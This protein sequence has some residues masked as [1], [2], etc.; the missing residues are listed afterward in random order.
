MTTP[1]LN[2]ELTVTATRPNTETTATT[3]SNTLNQQTSYVQYP[4]FNILINGTA[5]AYPMSFDIVTNNYSEASRFTATF[6]LTQTQAADLMSEA[7][8]SCEVQVTLKDADT[9]LSLIYGLVD[10][11]ELDALHLHVVLTG[12]D[13]AGLLLDTP[14]Q[15][16]YENMTSSQVIQQFVQEHADQG[17]K[18]AITATS[19]LI[20]RFYGESYDFTKFG[21]LYHP[22]NEW[23]F[24]LFLAQGEGFDLRL[25]GPDANGKLLD[26]KTLYFGPPSPSEAKTYAIAVDY[27]PPIRSNAE[28]FIILRSLTL[29]K[30]VQ[31]NVIAWNSFQ[32][33]PI[34][35]RVKASNVKAPSGG[36]GPTQNYTFLMPGDPTPEQALQYAQMKLR[37]ITAFERTVEVT[38]PFELDLTPASPVNVIGTGTPADQGYFIDQIM[39]SVHFEQGARETIRLKNHSPYTVV[40][41]S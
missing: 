11:V 16:P 22:T 20:G 12:R 40:P 10:N 9:P 26:S 18:G 35:Q 37:Q 1:N 38:V 3:A 24:A 5:V 23:S 27:G 2:M 7:N 6:P 25:G 28:H 39:R 17:L 8:L 30:D 4:R 13:L 19:G 36:F 33:R 34:I 32:M 41:V 21:D 31:V 29:A 15:Q 14:L